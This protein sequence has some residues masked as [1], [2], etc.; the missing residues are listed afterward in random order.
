MNR[1]RF[2]ARSGVLPAIASTVL[3]AAGAAPG[4]EVAAAE[5][6]AFPETFM[7][8][9]AAYGV[10]GAD[11]DL[12]VL[13]DQNLGTS[14]SFVDDLE[15]EDEAGVARFDGY[16]R[17]DERHRIEFGSLGIERH[18]RR[19]L[20][21]DLDIG[22][23]SF[24]VGD[25]VISNIEYELLKLGYAYSFYHSPQ[26]E[27]SFTSGIH[28]MSYEFDYRLV[29]D[30]TDETAEFSGPMPMFGLRLSYALDRRWSLHYDTEV[31][32]VEA[33]GAEGSFQNYEL[34]VRYRLDRQIMLGTGLVRFSMDITSDDAEW[35]G[36]IADTHQGFLLFAGYY[37]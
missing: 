3:L 20:T 12:T 24:S 7:L 32:F 26:V 10:R 6:L 2:T 9:L 13:S 15:G 16:Y 17:T 33:G 22:G 18:G 29:D 19:S 21:I 25:T 1:D 31:M 28:F 4:A 35:N 5:R 11:T 34:S 37:L 8:R 30:T 23:Q 27:L 14:F 36:R